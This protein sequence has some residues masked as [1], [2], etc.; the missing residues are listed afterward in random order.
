LTKTRIQRLWDKLD[1]LKAVLESNPHM[2]VNEA[3]KLAQDI[4]DLAMRIRRSELRRKLIARRPN[5]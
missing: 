5:Q 2:D 4:E 1:E 3:R